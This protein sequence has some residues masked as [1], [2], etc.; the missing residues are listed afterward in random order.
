MRNQLSLMDEIRNKININMVTCCNCDSI[1]L[2]KMNEDTTKC[3]ACKKYINL[4]DCE[5][6]F[7]E[8]MPELNKSK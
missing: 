7:Y 8:G 2:H 3:Y 4:N 1:I 5:D 6:Y